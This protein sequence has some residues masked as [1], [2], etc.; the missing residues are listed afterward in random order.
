MKRMGQ[1]SEAGRLVVKG[2]NKKIFTIEMVKLLAMARKRIPNKFL[3][4]LRT[5][6]S[7]EHFGSKDK[8]FLFDK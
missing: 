1:I 7:E 5:I 2:Q 8:T 3:K 4:I 6:L